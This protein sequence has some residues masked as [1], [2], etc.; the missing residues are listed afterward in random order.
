[1]LKL[2]QPLFEGPLDIIGDVHGEYTALRKLLGSLGYDEQG[3]HAENRRLIFVGDLVDRGH[4]SPAVLE[5]VMTLTR[6]GRAQAVMGN[7]ELNILMQTY[8]HGNGWILDP[9]EGVA[10]ERFRSVR[11]TPEQ[12]ER[13]LAF[14]STLP[15]AL[16]RSDLRVAHACWRTESVNLLHMDDSEI[17][18]VERF[19]HYDAATR[20][21]LETD[22]VMQAALR[23]EKSVFDPATAPPE[24]QPLPVP[25]HAQ[26]EVA[27]QHGN[28]LR[29]LM[30]GAARTT[31][32]PYHATGRWRMT[33]RT[34]WW[35]EYRERVP[36]I[37]G[38]FWR[39]FASTDA[40]RYGV[41]GQ[42]V[43]EGVE[44]HDWMGLAKNVYCIDYSVGKRYLARSDK[45]R[46]DKDRNDK[47][48]H[49]EDRNDKESISNE[50]HLSVLR[51]PEWQVH[52]DDGSEVSI[53]PPGL[54][55]YGV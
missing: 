53:G 41:F 9:P 21:R 2:V 30:T 5:L 55:G 26:A 47:G 13:F 17:P 32:M 46:N 40:K 38:H 19:R 25:A 23:Y 35:N 45:D 3:N 39:S 43:L 8:G 14:L 34:P 36:V 44:S 4:D 18:V 22:D 27:I 12:R 1:M 29:I 10:A 33:E 28:P 20:A 49:D 48:G 16:A 51:V 24:C 54:S 37:I 50:G 42:D 7:H 52:H 11:A 6:N 31:I 15:V